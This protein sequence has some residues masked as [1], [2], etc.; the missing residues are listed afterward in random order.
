MAPKKVKSPKV[1][2][3]TAAEKRTMNVVSGA[4]YPD[5]SDALM[6][7]ADRMEEASDAQRK[8]VLEKWIDRIEGVQL[9]IMRLHKL[10]HFKTKLSLN[11]D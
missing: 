5:F 7:L 1:A 8:Q 2:P 4:T 6:L 9:E 10:E 3:K 11:K